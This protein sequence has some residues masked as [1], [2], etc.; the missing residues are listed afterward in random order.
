MTATSITYV[1]RGELQNFFMDFPN[2][3]ELTLDFA[4]LAPEERGGT[5]KKFLAASAVSCFCSAL[6]G[7]LLARGAEYSEIRGSASVET[8][9]DDKKRARVQKIILH[10]EVVMSDDFEDVFERCKK[11]MEPGCLITAS[12]EPGIRVEHKV[13]LIHE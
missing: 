13:R 1:R 4:T 5:A 7:A 3:K 8:G 10:V 9:L 2:N 6:S 12:L 11:I